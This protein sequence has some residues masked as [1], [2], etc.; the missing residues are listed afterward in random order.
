MENGASN[1][2]NQEELDNLSDE[3][4]EALWVCDLCGKSTFKTE[5]DYLVSTTRHLGCQ[6]ELE[7]R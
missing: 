3:E 6:L 7:L 1:K 5:Y 2:M 4:Y